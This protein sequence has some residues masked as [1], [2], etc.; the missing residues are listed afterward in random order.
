MFSIDP[1]DFDD[2]DEDDGW[3]AYFNGEQEDEDDE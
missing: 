2:D 3:D 1:P